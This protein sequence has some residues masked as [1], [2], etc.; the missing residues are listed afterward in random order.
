MALVFIIYPL[1]IYVSLC[2][3][4]RARARLGIGLAAAALALVWVTNGGAADEG[5]ARFL[6][7][8]GAVPVALAALAQGLRRMIPEGAA[9]WVWPALA[10]GL[11]LSALAVFLML[12]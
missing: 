2:L 7:M 9:G 10:V 11:A 8:I 12:L 6:V 5:F 1:A 3:L 4:P